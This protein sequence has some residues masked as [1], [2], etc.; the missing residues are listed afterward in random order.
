MSVNLSSACLHSKWVPSQPGWHTERL[1]FKSRSKTKNKHKNNTNTSLY[2]CSFVSQKKKTFSGPRLRMTE[3][4]VI[5]RFECRNQILRFVTL[6]VT[7]KCLSIRGML[8]KPASDLCHG[9]QAALCVWWILCQAHEVE[10]PI[11]KVHVDL[12]ER[13]WYFDISTNTHQSPH[14]YFHGLRGHT[15]TELMIWALKW[16]TSNQGGCF[17]V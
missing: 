4:G 3:K 17:L 11:S 16:L 9:P 15:C 8:R 13:D 6:T 12:S 2:K 1:C 10:Y 14:A 7:F 5:S